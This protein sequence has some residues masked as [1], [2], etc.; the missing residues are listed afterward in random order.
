MSKKKLGLIIAVVFLLAGVYFV[1][2]YVLPRWGHDGM[3][4]IL[5]TC[6]ELPNEANGAFA[7]QISELGAGLVRVNF[8]A[9]IDYHWSDPTMNGASM[10]SHLIVCGS[11]HYWVWSSEEK[12][13]VIPGLIMQEH[14]FV[15]YDKDGAVIWNRWDNSWEERVGE[16]L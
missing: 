12:W 16:V 5:R 7:Y 1:G 6:P 11:P 3:P 10:G 2:S 4:G 15:V 13:E 14:V 9:F 8:I